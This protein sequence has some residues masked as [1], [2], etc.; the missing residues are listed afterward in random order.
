M[1]YMYKSKPK[2]FVNY[3]ILFLRVLLGFLE[4]NLLKIKKNLLES[5]R[6]P[7]GF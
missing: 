5:L 4:E 7:E 3:L 2:D 1:L 6:I